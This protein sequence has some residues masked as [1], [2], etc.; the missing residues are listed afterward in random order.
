M[1][2]RRPLLLSAAALPV[3]TMTAGCSSVRS[4]ESYDEVVQQTFRHADRFDLACIDAQRELVRYACMAANSHNTQPW[5]F[6]IGEG[7][8][9]L[10]ADHDRRCPV[11]DP[12][13]HHVHAS[14]GAAAE[15]IV[16]AAEAFGLRGDLALDEGKVSIKLEPA[17]SKRTAAFEAIPERQCTRASFDGRAVPADLLR[18]LEAVASSPSVDLFLLTGD[19]RKKQIIDFVVAG[20]SAQMDD[21][22]FI[23]ELRSW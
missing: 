8:I 22:A 4:K 11:V 13:D 10:T 16:T 2:R 21:D 12:V 5:I 3:W 9:D 15:N 7:C 14:L 23:Q 20:N 17:P 18:D 1:V 6:R 19:S